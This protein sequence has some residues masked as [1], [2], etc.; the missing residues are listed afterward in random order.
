MVV[1]LLSTANIALAQDTIAFPQSGNAYTPL[2]T[3]SYHLADRM[4]ILYPNAYRYLH[5]DQK[6]F[7]REEIAGLTTAF[8]GFDSLHKK[9]QFDVNY[10]C[11]DNDEFC[12]RGPQPYY[13]GSLFGFLYRDPATFYQFFTVRINPVIQNSFGFSSDSSDLRFVNSRGFE[14]RGSI[15]NKVGFY[16][17]ATDNQVRLPGYVSE[18]VAAAPQVVP[19]EGVAKIFKEGGYDYLSAHGY[20]TFNAT[21]HIA[22]Q[23]GQ[24][25]IFIGDG[26]R[27]MIW[28]DNSKD[29]LF[30]RITTKLWR[31]QYENYFTE[32]ANYD[33]SNIYNSL[34]HKKYAALHHIS[35]PITPTVQIGLFESVVF[36][37]TTSTGIEK[38]FDLN[39]LNPIIFYRAVESGLGSRDNVLLGANWKWNFLNSFSF[40][41]QFVLDEFV[42][43]Q[44]FSG[45][46]W[47]GN[48]NA[49]QVGLKYINAFTI[50]HF[51]LQFEHNF[52]RPYTYSY[53]D[54]N[55]SSY[56]HYGQALAHPLGANFGENLIALWYEPAPRW[57]INDH[58][59]MA[60]YGSDT[61]GS[62]WGGNIFLNYNTYESEYNNS[63]GQGVSNHLL[64]NDLVVS[65]EFW[66]NA[67][68]DAHVIYRTV[69]SELD[70]LDKNELFYSIGVR[71]N[72]SLA[73]YLF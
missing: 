19:G 37:R 15:D 21:R 24:D 61:L 8:A 17:Y 3:M 52:A 67:F 46:G 22:F 48:K 7:L 56:T 34:V 1:M 28:S 29:Q 54:E 65:W 35:V 51:D 62:N 20:F 40:Y 23:F 11:A 55:G 58:F 50:D 14:L 2:N 26:I 12:R 4:D 71:L 68:I 73:D 47:W 32:L 25:K 60:N 41:G 43:S 70:A 45:D 39:Y 64:L 30:L 66:H 63:I 44:L 13:S 9:D 38:G 5:T 42:F 69:N 57:F 27:S 33:G 53:E 10:L 16:W 18:R 36:E 6:P 59:M 72:Q 31:V 49:G